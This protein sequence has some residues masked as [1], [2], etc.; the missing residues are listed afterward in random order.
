LTNNLNRD[1]DMVGTNILAGIKTGTR[2]MCTS[3]YPIEKVRNFPYLIN[4]RILHQNGD[5]FKEYL[6]RRIYLSSLFQ[7]SF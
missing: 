1:G 7:K 3:S 5:G 6:R 2:R 4:V